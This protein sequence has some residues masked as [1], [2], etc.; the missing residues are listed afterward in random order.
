MLQDHVVAALARSAA[1][2]AESRCRLARS[3]S[4][5]AQTRAHMELAR[6]QIIRSRVLLKGTDRMVGDGHGQGLPIG[7]APSWGTT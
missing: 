6:W 7:Q 4:S 2:T 1:V 3:G 5:L